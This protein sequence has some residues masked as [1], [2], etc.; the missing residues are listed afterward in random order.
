MKESCGSGCG[1]SAFPESWRALLDSRL[2]SEAQLQAEAFEHAELAAW[3]AG[4]GGRPRRMGGGSGQ[5]LARAAAGAASGTTPSGRGRLDHDVS[6]QSLWGQSITLDTN[7]TT[8]NFYPPSRQA[9][10]GDKS[11]YV[12]EAIPMEGPLDLDKTGWEPRHLWVS[13]AFQRC[14]FGGNVVTE[15]FVRGIV[16]QEGQ[17][18]ALFGTFTPPNG[19]C[20]LWILAHGDI[21]GR[22]DGEYTFVVLD[23]RQVHFPCNPCFTFQSYGGW[24]AAHRFDGT[25]TSSFEGLHEG[26]YDVDGDLDAFGDPGES[27]S[28]TLGSSSSNDAQ[29][30]PTSLD[31]LIDSDPIALS[32]RYDFQVTGTL[33]GE[34]ESSHLGRFAFSHTD[35]VDLGYHLAFIRASRA[36]GLSHVQLHVPMDVDWELQLDFEPR[37]PVGPSFLLHLSGQHAHLHVDPVIPD[38]MP[39]CEVVASLFKMLWKRLDAEIDAVYSDFGSSFVPSSFLSL[40]GAI[41]VLLGDALTELDS[42]LVRAYCEGRL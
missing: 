1:S 30:N 14:R 37:F 12:G 26:E 28:D 15:S 25:R 3:E 21:N 31:H 42:R 20:G 18:L 13:E 5:A 19:G 38:D 39:D 11:R 9:G 34:F 36:A 22:G 2:L 24:G 23:E 32:I 10:A 27:L 6:I 16:E 4:Y 17:R 8:E 35:N 7:A 41:H 40:R 29:Q 33:P